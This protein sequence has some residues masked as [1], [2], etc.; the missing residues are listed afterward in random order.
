LNWLV[1]GLAPQKMKI[2]EAIADFRG[3]EFVWQGRRSVW[4][5]RAR[6]DAPYLLPARLRQR[7]ATGVNGVLAEQL[8][9][10]QELIV[11]RQTIGAA[12]GAG[13]GLTLIRA[14]ISF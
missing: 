6:S 8:F 3:L 9:D 1:G 12:E 4:R 5:R 14:Q 2:P 13:L 11:L 7:V 10:A